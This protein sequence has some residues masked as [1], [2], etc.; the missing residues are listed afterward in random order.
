MS[1]FD[2]KENKGLIWN[3]MN[4]SGV[5]KGIPDVYI[6]QVKRDFENKI[7]TIKTNIQQ[8]DTLTLLNKRV[9]SEMMSDMAKYR[10]SSAAASAS[11]A[12]ALAPSSSSYSAVPAIVTSKDVSTQRQQQFKD[13]F[14]KKKEEFTSMFGNKPP[15]TIDFSDKLDKPIG[16]EMED[17]LAATIARRNNDLNIVLEKQDTTV[18][19]AAKWI[20]ADT[21][22]NNNIIKIGQNTL[23]DNNVIIDVTKT[24]SPTNPKQVRFTESPP[25]SIA[26][27]SNDDDTD[28]DSSVSTFLSI[29]NNKNEYDTNTNNMDS[30]NNMNMDTLYDKIISAFDERLK[31]MEETQIEILELL[32]E[33]NN[34]NNNANANANANP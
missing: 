9:L 18:A 21:S 30:N 5:F 16:S 1:A 29:L 26:P 20:N 13:G 14:D 34:S 23:L 33:K 27:T 11:L 15:S 17:M 31:R 10:T 12:L 25:T 8:K 7:I 2:T 3:I 4:D 22:S 32:R 6:D 19:T 24:K 28:N